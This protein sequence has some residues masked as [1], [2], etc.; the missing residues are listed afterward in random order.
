MEHLGHPSHHLPCLLRITNCG[1]HSN[2]SC[3]HI[4]L[5]GVCRIARNLPASS[6]R[7]LQNADLWEFSPEKPTIFQVLATA[8]RGLKDGASAKDVCSALIDVWRIDIALR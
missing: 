3:A 6:A 1:I 7:L 2:V 4:Q 8:Q 5:Y